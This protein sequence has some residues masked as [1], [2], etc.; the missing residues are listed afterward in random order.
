MSGV[1]TRGSTFDIALSEPV[2]R[3]LRH[4][5]E[6]VGGLP[7]LELLD[8][9]LSEGELKIGLELLVLGAESGE[10][11]LSVVEVVLQRWDLV[12]ILDLLHPF[13]NRLLRASPL[14]PVRRSSSKFRIAAH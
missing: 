8:L 14:R 1:V 13:P 4:V 6:R 11:G 5:D 7:A 10:L 3:V 12:A 2:R 9:E